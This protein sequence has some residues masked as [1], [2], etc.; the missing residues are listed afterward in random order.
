MAEKF[1]ITIVSYEDENKE[2]KLIGIPLSE[3]ELVSYIQDVEKVKHNKG[4][5]KF[6]FIEYT[7]H[8]KQH[9]VH[10]YAFFSAKNPGH[11][12]CLFLKI[13]VKFYMFTMMIN[14]MHISGAQWRI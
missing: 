9:P 13:T 2:T 4:M 7:R 6:Y 3:E 10:Q 8:R 12:L 5:Y 1:E 11:T 14:T